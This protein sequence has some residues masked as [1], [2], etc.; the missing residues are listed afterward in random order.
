M[1]K[2]I[3]IS[4][5]LAMAF[6]LCCQTT[7][8]LTANSNNGYGLVYDLPITAIDVTIEAEKIVKQP[9]IFYRYAKKY[10]NID[11]PISEH[12]QSWEIKSVVIS[13]RGIAD[14]NERY[15]MEFK[16]GKSPF[17]I[18]S[19]NN[20]PVAIN[21]E[22]T[23][24]ELEPD[25]PISAEP[26]P[27]PL[28]TDAAQQVLSQEMLQSQSSAKQAEIAAQQ[29]YVLRQ[30]RTDLITG[31]ADQMPPDGQAMKLILDNISAQEAALTAMFAGTEQRSTEVRT[32]SITPDN[33]ANDT[34]IARLSGSNGLTDTY[35]LSGEPIYLFSEIIEYGQLPINEKSGKAKEF[36]K[37]GLAYRI[38]GKAKVSI[39]YN[40]TILT[41]KT[42]DIAQ[43]GPVFGLDPNILV[44]SN[45]IL[46]GKKAPAYVIFDPKTGAIKELGTIAQ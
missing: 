13:T 12:S 45:N 6:S 38:P 16:K 33:M 8:K 29:I 17:M 35:D 40:G 19:E 7:Q 32:Y 43:Y 41:E 21:T 15:I 46:T 1:K 42:L 27:T 31:Q 2:Y 5:F 23:L 39:E 22:N 26:T 3:L 34:I 4:T 24:T 37:G 14:P 28:E 10:L 30:S 11:E 36:P 18:V 25:L 9:G 20:F 44:G